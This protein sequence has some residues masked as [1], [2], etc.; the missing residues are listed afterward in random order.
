MRAIIENMI[1]PDYVL[2]YIPRAMA[3]E[4][5]EPASKEAAAPQW[6]WKFREEVQNF[7]NFMQILKIMKNFEKLRITISKVGC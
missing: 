5:L 1:L 4:I 3:M 2:C 7:G 6:F